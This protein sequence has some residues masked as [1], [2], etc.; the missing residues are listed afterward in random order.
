MSTPFDRLGP[1]LVTTD[2]EVVASFARDEAALGVQGGAGGAGPLAV[3]SPRSTADVAAVLAIAHEHRVPVVVRGAGSGLS[4]AAA[5]PDGS[6]VLSTRRLARVLEVDPVERLA[7]VQPG[8]V[9]GDLRAAAADAG[10]FYPPDP[11]SVAFSTVGGNV[12]TN[13]GGMCCVKYGVTGDFVLGLEVVLA[14]GTVARTGRRTAKGVAGYD[15]TALVVGSEGTL[16]VITEITVRLLPAPGPARTLVA[17][18]PSLGA[19]GAAVAAVTR[20]GLDLSMLE[21]MDRTTL[22]AVDR[23]TGMGL[24]ADGTPA[25]MLLAQGDGG[26]AAAVLEAMAVLCGDAGAEDV[27]VADDAVEGEALL[28]ARRQA[29]PALERLGDWILDDVCVPRGRVVD[30]LEG[31][32]RVAAAQALTIGV[33]G[34][35]GDGNMHPTIVH[36]AADPASVAAAARAFDAITS[37]ALDLGGTITGEH[38]VGRLKRDWLA[39]E[40]DPGAM[41]MSRAVKAALDPRGILNP[42]CVLEP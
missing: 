36:D 10:L 27:V 3:V 38:G 30:L 19:A 12:A 16:G 39:R 23:L 32:E 4:G 8:V 40:L 25:A 34:H 15:L 9:T 22:D 21:V 31:I 2:P 35:A 24:G 42:G 11:G 6:V 33:F 17:T 28:E 37:L 1:D 18:F 14:D 5:A 7:V 29:L 41:A 20:A 26:S 13:A